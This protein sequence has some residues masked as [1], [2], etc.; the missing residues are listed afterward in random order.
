VNKKKKKGQKPKKDFKFKG[1]RAEYDY[2]LPVLLNQAC[3]Y[4]VNNPDGVY[5]DGTLG[6]GGHS[7]E[8]LNRLS[9]KGKL[10]SFDK[11]ENAIRHCQEKFWGELSKGENSRI[12][13]MNECYSRSCGIP[14]DRG[15]IDG[16]LLD[17]GLSS[18]Q[19]DESYRGFSYRVDSNIDMR[20]SPN[21]RSAKEIL[22][23]AN[24]EEIEDILRKYG[25]EPF[26]KRIAR[27]II[28]KRRALPIQTT[29]DLRAIVE[30]TVPARFITKSL[31][32][33]FQA[34][35]IATNNELEVLENTL[36]DCLPVLS[37]GGRIVIIAYHS[38][39]DRIVKTFFKDH[40]FKK[41]RNKYAPNHAVAK[42]VPLL[43]IITSKPIVPESEEIQKNP[44]ARS[45]KMRV[46]ERI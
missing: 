13:L 22:H 24:E 8:I 44:R 9:D 7:Q 43:K 1:K 10:F 12:V 46:A 15:R 23:A 11:D 19:L 30:E 34:F 28:E 38:L 42:N 41:S 16:I 33:V 2:H 25:E 5:I 45:A 29:F 18:R 4:L 31:S 26:A 17:L 37:Q 3:D 27:R 32:R 14:G 21:G 35:R 20:F 40:S 39:E 36:N 6:G